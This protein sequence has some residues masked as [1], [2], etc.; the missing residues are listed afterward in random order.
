M[1]RL[2]PALR[3]GKPIRNLAQRLERDAPGVSTAHHG[4]P[5]GGT[6]LFVRRYWGGR[7]AKHHGD[8]PRRSPGLTLAQPAAEW[9]AELAREI[10]RKLQPHH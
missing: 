5:M 6:G 9:V 7:S 1:E 2:T 8:G 10:E 3:R 4:R